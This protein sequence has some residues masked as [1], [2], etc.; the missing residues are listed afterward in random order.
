MPHE[1][2]G[3]SKVSHQLEVVGRYVAVAPSLGVRWRMR[4]GLSLYQE[5][6]M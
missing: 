2:S 1:L 3:I 6:M 5:R 4:D